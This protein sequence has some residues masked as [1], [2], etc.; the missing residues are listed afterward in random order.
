M[1]KTP[2][3]YY[4]GKQNMLR[5]ILPNIPKHRIYTEAFFG[6]GA[7][8]FAKEPAESEIINDKN[9]QVM[10]F[11]QVC[12]SDF[13][14]LK[15]KV[16]ATVFARSTYSVAWAMYRMPHLFSKRQQAWAFY[17]ATN[18]GFGCHIGSW[19]MDK[20]GK[21]VKAFLN[22]KIQF[23]ASIPERLERTQIESHNAIKVIKQYDT[24]DAFHYIDP[25]YIDTNM[26]HYQ[27]Y[28]IAD[29][30]ELLKALTQ[31]KGKFLLSGFPNDIL[32][33]YIKEFGWQMKS[34]NQPKTAAKGSLGVSRKARKTEVLVAN[35]DLQ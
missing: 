19:G 2:I 14:A 33:L 3:S 32:T 12:Q 17:I 20:Y 6:G 10:N 31:L 11:Y 30:T 28:S 27:G 35:Y 25:P 7:V 15:A 16:E 21:R 24:V 8:F 9:A 18:M 1:P 5:H 13:A 22:K 29:Y 23:D 26:G 34:F 4:G